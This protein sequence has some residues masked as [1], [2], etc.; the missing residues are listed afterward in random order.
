LMI[1]GMAR[2]RTRSTIFNPIRTGPVS[3]SEKNG[4]HWNGADQEDYKNEM[5]FAFI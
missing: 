5:L 4:E 2:T 1:H 3:R